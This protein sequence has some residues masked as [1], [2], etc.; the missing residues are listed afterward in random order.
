MPAAASANACGLSDNNASFLYA[1]DYTTGGSVSA[2]GG[3]AGVSLGSGLATA[4]TLF[5]LPNGTVKAIV[6]VSDNLD[7]GG[8]DMGNSKQITPPVNNSTTSS[9]RRVSWRELSTQ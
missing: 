1:L 2:S 9:L 6:R 8:T 3:V 5:E 4:P 7:H